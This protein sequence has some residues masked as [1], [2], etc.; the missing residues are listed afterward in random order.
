MCGGAI[1]RSGIPRAIFARSSAQL[2]EL[3]APSATP[4]TF[5]W[6]SDGPHLHPESTAPVAC[7]HL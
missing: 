5:E 1:A 4:T 3:N 6:A 7:Y 2:D